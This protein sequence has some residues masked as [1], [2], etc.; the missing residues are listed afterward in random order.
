MKR[1][2]R[3]LAALYRDYG[4]GY[5]FA[6][7]LLLSCAIAAVHVRAMPSP[8]AAAATPPQLVLSS[9]KHSSE[10]LSDWSA[11]IKEQFMDDLIHDQAQNWTVVM[12]NEGGD[13]DS[14]VSSLAYAFHL[15]HL[16]PPVKA[17]ALL[18]TQEDALDLRPENVLALKEAHMKPGHADLLTLDEMP[19]HRAQVAK[20]IGAIV[21][22]DHP[23]LHSSW[24]AEGASKVRGLIDHHQDRGSYPDAN[25]RI[26]KMTA[27]CS[28]LSA[29]VLFDSYTYKKMPMHLADLLFSVIA[30][31]SDAF[32]KGPVDL[33]LDRDISR[34]L[35]PMTT[36]KGQK[37]EKA[38][39]KISKS[40]K[41]ARKDLDK[42]SIRD[43]LRRDYKGDIVRSANQ[44]ESIHLGFA[45]MPI[46]LREQINRTVT[47]EIT[48]WFAIESKW[49]IE[50]LGAD[51]SCALTSW[52][53]SEKNKKR[54]I[55]LVVKAGGRLTHEEAVDLFNHIVSDIRN[56][57][58][59]VKNWDGDLGVF[60]CR[61]GRVK[62]S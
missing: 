42:L 21:L 44:K 57:E 35:L 55:V 51:V 33:D 12:G 37:L 8:D 47:G 29:S 28:T 34:K 20:R 52:K 32:S 24:G 25:P 9:E 7:G 27:S 59:P 14:L 49:T 43:L 36:W 15:N 23:V 11:L 53:D 60:K 10:P 61:N 1:V 48:E 40:L 58:L 26:V 13:L 17:V 16:D 22:V 46:S 39:R 4:M 54:E 50:E 56:S 2:V 62:R 41:K 6:V 5:H 45:S 18:Q 30:L 38:A 31:D 19:Y 3:S